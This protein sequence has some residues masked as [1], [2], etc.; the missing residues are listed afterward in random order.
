MERI[1]CLAFL[2]TC[3][4]LELRFEDAS[5]LSRSLANI[6]ACAL[7]VPLSHLRLA[8]SNRSKTDRSL[9]HCQD[10]TACWADGTAGPP[11]NELSTSER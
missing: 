8:R 7:A 9:M 10:M 6:K 3:G 2:Q 5:V 1:R 11:N 4:H